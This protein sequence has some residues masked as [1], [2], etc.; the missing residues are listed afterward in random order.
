MID[1]KLIL[2]SKKKSF[3]RS[4]WEEILKK[5]ILKRIPEEYIKEDQIIFLNSE[6]E[7]KKYFLNLK[8]NNSNK[9]KII[10]ILIPLN[11]FLNLIKFLDN[12]D[13]ILDEETKIII[14][15]FSIS[16][17]QIFNIFSLLGLIKNFKKSLFFSRKTF[18]IFLNC[19]NFEISKKL[20]DIS[21]P[22]DIPIVT[23]LSSLII[24][25]FP[26]LSIISFANIYYLRKRVK[27]SSDNKIMSLIIPC[28]NEQD[29][30]ENIVNEARIKLRF[31]Y[32]LVFIDDLSND[33]TYLRIKNSI[34]INQDLN[35]K[36]VSGKGEGK[37]RAVDIGVRNSDG[38]YCAILDAD[39]TVRMEDI[40]SFYSAISI[41]NGDVINGTRLIYKLEENSMR[42][43]NI[44]GN[45]F[46]SYLISY[47]TSTK[48]SD[49][50]CGTKCFK[51]SDWEIFEKF[52]SENKLDDIWGD[53]NIIFASSYYGYKLIDLPVRYY[54]RISG[55]TKMKRRFYYFL[56]MLKLCYLAFLK[57]KIS[58]KA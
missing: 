12:I 42:F 13:K 45:K 15:Y 37:S 40:N 44:L 11:N 58:Y 4:K 41:G 57:F 50:L 10:I 8:S 2:E 28:K 3:L 5:T 31:P 6:E 56:N 7:I 38:F 47:I 16:W 51:K 49:T 35:I 22:F 26:F 46:F 34:N 18:Q 36:I 55:E 48:I 54:E 21:I 23:K 19:T 29:N 14:N 30:I 33:E 52:R 20:N 53:F 17:K 27:K 24:N 43:L 39:L 25:V 32:Q 1:E 9:K